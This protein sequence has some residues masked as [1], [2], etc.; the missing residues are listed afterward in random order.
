MSHRREQDESMPDHGMRGV[1]EERHGYAPDVGRGSEE[2][3]RAGDRAFGP[4]PEGPQWPGREPSRAER[5]GVPA[6]DMEARTPLG[7]GTSS[8]RRAEHIAQKEPE[9]GRVP[10]G[11]R[12]KS[13]RPHGKS[14][15]EHDTGVT[16]QGPSHEESPHLPTGDQA[17]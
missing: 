17:G 7:V 13:R 8:S 16:P 9:A 6:T 12:G 11:L 10:G 1:D 4:P 2:A 14:A 15:P 5:F 3:R